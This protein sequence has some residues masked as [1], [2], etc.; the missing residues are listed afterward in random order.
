MR[1][2]SSLNKKIVLFLT[3]FFLSYNL[4]GENVDNEERV[5]KLYIATFNRAPDKAGLD[6]WVNEMKNNGWSLEMVAQSMFMQKETKELYPEGTSTEDF[7]K[8]VYKNTLNRVADKSG[9]EYWKKELES[10]N[11]SKEHF[12]IAIINGANGDDIKV[13]NNKTKIGEYFAIEKGKNDLSLSKSIMK[14][15]SLERNSINVAKD[16]IDNKNSSKRVLISYGNR[17]EIYLKWWKSDSSEATLYNS[18]TKTLDNANPILSKSEIGYYNITCK[19]FKK[20][21]EGVEYKCGDKS[22][23][24]YNNKTNY[25]LLKRDTIEVIGTINILK[26]ENRGV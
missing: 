12:I 3:L 13:L 16:K 18:S 14:I 25:I 19:P 6:Y 9:I 5:I 21:N 4:Y 11:I 7:I 10:G 2:F 8:A 22:I 24:I 1:F 17:G 23:K 15:V 20:V 26:I